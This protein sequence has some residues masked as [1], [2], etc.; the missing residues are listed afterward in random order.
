MSGHTACQVKLGKAKSATVISLINKNNLGVCCQ[1][2]IRWGQ[3]PS[4]A[5]SSVAFQ[6]PPFL[7][8]LVSPTGLPNRLPI[9][10]IMHVMQVLSCLLAAAAAAASSE[11]SLPAVLE[12]DLV[13][14]R[15][16]TYA[17][18]PLFPFI[19]AVQ[20][21]NLVDT[22]GPLAPIRLW[23]VDN[24]N[25]TITSRKTDF[26]ISQNGNSS[27]SDNSNNIFFTYR[28]IGDAL[29]SEGTWVI[30]WDV[31]VH[32]CSHHSAEYPDMIVG[33]VWGRRV[34]P[35]F[36]IF[37]IAK[38]GKQPDYATPWNKSSNCL[39]PQ[40]QD[41]VSAAFNVTALLPLSG[42]SRTTR[43]KFPGQDFCPVLSEDADTG[44]A[45]NPCAAKLDSTGASSISSALVATDCANTIPRASC[46]A[47]NG[48]PSQWGSRAGT[49]TIIALVVLVTGI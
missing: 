40:D 30:A 11:T 33:D 9:L 20:N 18:T 13:F 36:V 27:S 47:K 21:V 2:L 19:F 3:R 32:N 15:N 7:D 38:D 16:E 35:K 49:I 6:Q 29:A 12:L 23:R 4:T 31:R 14:P 22:L 37:T 48:A 42:Q 26:N 24:Y 25:A 44:P 43:E 10:R 8:F 45:T 17:P 1:P 34:D 5:V 46:P 41:R 39:Q 28:D